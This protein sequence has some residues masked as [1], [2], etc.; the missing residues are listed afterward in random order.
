MEAEGPWNGPSTPLQLL[1]GRCSLYWEGPSFVPFASS[2]RM[3]PMYALTASKSSVD[4]I[5]RAL[6]ESADG[7]RSS[8]GFEAEFWGTLQPRS[9]TDEDPLSGAGYVHIVLVC[10]ARAPYRATPP[11]IWQTV[12]IAERIRRAAEREKK[13][14]KNFPT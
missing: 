8:P 2:T 3:P 14:K 9:P 13:T 10:W 11:S 6:G 4:A 5:A 1:R 12:P 7:L